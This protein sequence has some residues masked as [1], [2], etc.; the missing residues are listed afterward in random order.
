MA[1]LPAAAQARLSRLVRDGDVRIN[2]EIVATEIRVVA[3]AAPSLDGDVQEHRF[4]ADLYRRLAASRID[5]PPFRD[6]AED[7]PALAMRLVEDLTP[8]GSTPRTF[9]Q[10]ALALLSALAWPGN[11]A[12]LRAVIER[13]LAVTSGAVIPVE[14][15][16]PV[17]AARPRAR[18]VPSGRKPARGPHPVRARL[19]CSRPPI[20]W[21]ADG[22]RGTGAGHPAS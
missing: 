21:L 10:A 5:L 16:L 11:L 2:G 13:V 12:E 18:A 6:R 1:E 22:R 17:A 19:Y 3:S 8:A 7:V 4:R 15:V 20:S 14:Q 9:T